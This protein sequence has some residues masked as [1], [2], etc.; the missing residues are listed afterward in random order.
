MDSRDCLILKVLK[1]EKSITKTARRLYIS[2]PT[3][4][5]RLNRLETDFN[6]KLLV[7]HAG[8]VYFTEAGN[9]LVDY[10][11]KLLDDMEEVKAHIQKIN[12]CVEGTIHV[13]I[14]TVFSKYRLAH[15]LKQFQ[16]RFPRINV[17]LKT[18]S[19]TFLLPS[20]LE[21]GEVHLII[22]RG[23]LE[24]HGVQHILMEEP[25]GI[26]SS[27]NIQLDQLANG[28]LISTHVS[29]IMQ[30]DVMFYEWA[31][32]HNIDLQNVHSIEVDS[33]EGCLQLVL[34]DMGWTVLPK[35]HITHHKNLFFYPLISPDGKLLTRETVLAYS[36]DTLNDVAAEKFITFVTSECF[37]ESIRL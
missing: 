11:C 19:S 12:Q 15:I 5:Y 7:R 6:A 16:K 35:I 30:S 23:R 4:T 24:W 31:K 2:Q 20:M 3:L 33:I 10:A 14:S 32:S 18:G 17:V 26:I 21:K 25:V 1:E 36:A 22:R 13:G 9:Y 28:T 37:P 8:G 27:K 29:K 34:L